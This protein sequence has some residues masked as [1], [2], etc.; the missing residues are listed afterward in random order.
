MYTEWKGVSKD[1]KAANEEY[2]MMRHGEERLASLMQS[3]DNQRIA[4]NVMRL[5]R[6][7]LANMQVNWKESSSDEMASNENVRKFPQPLARK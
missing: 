3:Q 2:R 6:Q 1:E 7:E 5:E 4:E